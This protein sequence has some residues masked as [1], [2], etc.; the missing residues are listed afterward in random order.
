MWKKKI[1]ERYLIFSQKNLLIN[2]PLIRIDN[3]MHLTSLLVISEY[4]KRIKTV[5]ILK[6]NIGKNYNSN[7]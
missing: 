4:K 7:S 5:P 3:M 2:S 1:M 6:N